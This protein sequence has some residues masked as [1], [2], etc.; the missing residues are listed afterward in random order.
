VLARPD[1]AT[2][3][4]IELAVVSTYSDICV[5]IG[6]SWGPGGGMQKDRFV[7]NPFDR[8]SLS[9]V[10]EAPPGCREL[11][12][13]LAVPHRGVAADLGWL[14]VRWIDSPGVAAL[15]GGAIVEEAAPASMADAAAA[16]VTTI[17]S[18]YEVYRRSCEWLAE[19]WADRQN[20]DSLVAEL[21]RAPPLGRQT[22]FSGGDW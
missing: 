6:A 18:S 17:V 10:L 3:A 1:G 20:A 15:P 19:N 8:G 21:L 2:H 14:R 9:V 11:R 5:A 22:R 13:E 7:L 4:W 16:A 12:L